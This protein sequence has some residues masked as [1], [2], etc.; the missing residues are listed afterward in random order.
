MSVFERGSADDVTHGARAVIARADVPGPEKRDS[1]SRLEEAAGLALAIGIE[2]VARTSFRVRQVKSA[3]LFGSGQVEQIADLAKEHEAELVI[4]DN[5]L[6]PVQQSNLEKATG[7]KVIDRTGLILE[8]F[9]ERAATNEGRLQVELA[10]LDYQAGRLVRS[11]THLERQ[12]GGFGFLGGPGETQIEADRRMIRDRMAKIRREL[13][14]VTR[15]RGLHRARR[16]RAPWPVI[17]LVGYTNA[18]KSTLFNRMTGA[19][20]MAKDMLFATLDPTMRQISLPGLDKAILSDTVGFVSDLPTQLIAA[21][22]ATL[23]EVIYADLIIHVRDI[24]H[25]DSEA[26]RTDVMEVLSELG[27]MAGGHSDTDIEDAPDHP[28]PAYLEVWNKIDLLH[29]AEREDILV[30]A[31]R[32]P[33]VVTASA[34]TGEGVDALRR[35]ISNR[36]TAGSRIH[37][38]HLP[39][40]DGASLAWLH[41]Y[42]EVLQISSA[43]TEE[44][45]EGNV[46]TVSVRLSD[47]AHARFLAR[48]GETPPSEDEDERGPWTP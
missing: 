34:I 45:D 20:V 40:S 33:D 15:T 6:S 11:W 19:D 8:I 17:A 38:V 27:V 2:V 37:T 13:D 31:H 42:G 48:I 39:T 24:A 7:A 25:I 29:G 5:A 36:M 46:L 22:R 23:E 10:H 28:Q 41:E 47:A 43:G 32:H 3:T 1:E 35:A 18:G 30:A 14:Q 9:G 16:Q 4:V 21:F 44:A 26:Q 12:R